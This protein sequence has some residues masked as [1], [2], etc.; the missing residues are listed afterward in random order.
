MLDELLDSDHGYIA[1]GELAIVYLA[2]GNTDAAV[3]DLEK[4]LEEHT[5]MALTI[6]NPRF[7]NLRSDPRF[8]ELVRRVGFPE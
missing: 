8:Q 7:A 2:L 6:R 4:A 3:A 1:P 5:R